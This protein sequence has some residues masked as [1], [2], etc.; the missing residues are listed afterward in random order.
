MTPIVHFITSD[1]SEPIAVTVP[2][3]TLVTDAAAQAGLNVGQPCG[4]QGRCGRCIVQVREGNVR[5]RST[6]HL[7]QDDIEDGYALACQS[8]VDGDAT[9][10]A[11]SEETIERRLTSERISNGLDVPADYD[12]LRS[13]NIRRYD[14]VLS[15]PSL[16]DQTDDWSRLKTGLAVQYGLTKVDCSLNV[17]RNLGKALRDGDWQVNVLVELLD[18]AEPSSGRILA[19]HPG[20]SVSTDPIWAAAID[21]G[22]TTVSFWLVNLV[23]GKVESQAVE[24]NRQIDRGEEVISR[25]IY[26]SKNGPDELQSKV[27]A[28]IN[29]LCQSACAQVGTLP[30]RYR[31][32]GHRGQ[33]HHGAF[34][35]GDFSRFHSSGAF[36]PGCQPS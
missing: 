27:V 32:S 11:K 20:V 16:D 2:E 13:Q 36:C 18:Q 23:T 6:M 35:A 9:I 3:H 8:L 19:V 4:G 29:E 33:P 7:T 24:Y 28:T 12:F 30:R 5:R 10:F 34:V 22:T 14:L 1:D 17:L 21:I 26:A 31:Q 25:I 15:P